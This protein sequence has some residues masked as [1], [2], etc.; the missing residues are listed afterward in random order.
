MTQDIIL[1]VPLFAVAILATMLAVTGFLQP[2][3]LSEG[4]D[5]CGRDPLCRPVDVLGVRFVVM[6]AIPLVASDDR[7][8]WIASKFKPSW[9]RCRTT[10]AR[11]ASSCFKP[12]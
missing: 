10:K 1:L 6:V 5:R 8:V 3:H 4:R 12:G 11:L 7:Q 9:P 2:L